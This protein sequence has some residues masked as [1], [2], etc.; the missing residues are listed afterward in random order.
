MT[1]PFRRAV[2]PNSTKRLFV[3]RSTTSDATDRSNV[4]SLSVGTTLLHRSL[5]NVL[6][7]VWIDHRKFGYPIMDL[8][9]I[10]LTV[11]SLRH[12]RITR[13]LKPNRYISDI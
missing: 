1:V 4:V 5:L 12:R 11:L 3:G 8:K 9:F 7:K 2:K 13:Y 10:F 6:T